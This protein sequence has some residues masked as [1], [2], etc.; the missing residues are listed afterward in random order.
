MK[1]FNDCMSPMEKDMTLHQRTLGEL[2]ELDDYKKCITSIVENYIKM[3]DTKINS[4][5]VE[6]KKASEYMIDNIAYTTTELIT[7]LS[8][9]GKITV[10]LFYD[11]NIESLSLTANV[12]ITNFYFGEHRI[13]FS[14]GMTWRE[15]IASPYNVDGHFTESNGAILYDSNKKIAHLTSI[16]DGSYNV[17]HPNDQIKNRAIYIDV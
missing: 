4:Q 9:E 16:D 2:R 13:V 12:T 11:P 10:D 14:D 3:I 5:D 1:P 8:E 7:K 15:F 6:I 17:V